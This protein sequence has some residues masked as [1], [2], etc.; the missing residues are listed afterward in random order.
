MTSSMP[1]HVRGF[2]WTNWTAEQLSKSPDS[3]E[4]VAS[5]FDGIS[6]WRSLC[7][8]EE[9]V[10]GPRRDSDTVRHGNTMC[11]CGYPK[12]DSG[13]RHDL[14]FQQTRGEGRF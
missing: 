2:C 7:L 5:R 11:D 6:D 1:I 4:H 10:I 13:N 9:Q 3:H 14:W 8:Q 12:T